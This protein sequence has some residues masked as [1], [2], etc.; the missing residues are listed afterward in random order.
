MSAMPN[1]PIATVTGAEYACALSISEDAKTIREIADHF[2]I[3]PPYAYNLAER[4]RAAG[5]VTRTK[6][7]R[8]RTPYVYAT[9]L[10]MQ[11]VRIVSHRVPVEQ[12][13]R[14]RKEL[15]YIAELRIAGLTG[16]ELSDRFRERFPDRSHAAVIK[17]LVPKA[18]R[19]G[20][21][22]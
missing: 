14:I 21:C 1:N 22:R 17:N 2:C 20:L 11:D 3:S 7:D 18:R 6:S 15:I 4:L 8:Y 13:T 12:A 5:V 10:E 9:I 16:R 19:A